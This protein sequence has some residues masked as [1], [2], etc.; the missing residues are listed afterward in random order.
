MLFSYVITKSSADLRASV[1]TSN[2]KGFHEKFTRRSDIRNY[3]KKPVLNF[4]FLWITAFI[5]AIRPL[6]YSLRLEPEI[7]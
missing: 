5:S 2:L 4:I 1:R 3:R 7:P 6:Q